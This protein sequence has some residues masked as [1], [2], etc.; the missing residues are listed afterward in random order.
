MRLGGPEIAM[1]PLATSCRH[2]SGVKVLAKRML[3]HQMIEH[4]AIV[5]LGC[6]RLKRLRRRRL[7]DEVKA[8]LASF[9]SD[10]LDAVDQRLGGGGVEAR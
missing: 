8:V 2:S 3:P 9:G 6:A 10:R 7:V 4:A 1:Q 5:Q